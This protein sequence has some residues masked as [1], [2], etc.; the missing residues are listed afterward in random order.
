MVILSI[1]PSSTRVGVAMLRPDE[2]LAKGMLISPPTQSG[3]VKLTAVERIEGIIARL[4]CSINLGSL[5]LDAVLVETPSQ[6]THRYAKGSG[7]AGLAL[8]GMAVGAV[9][10]WCRGRFGPEI[11]HAVP[12]DEW[13]SGSSAKR[14]TTHIRAQYPSVDWS[15]DSGADLSDAIAMGLWWMNRQRIKA[16]TQDTGRNPAEV[17]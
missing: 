9:W 16:Q 17:K 5:L 6:H 13:A 2:T 4:H 11:V 12:V 8:Y 15:K 1:D 7:G 14:R 10:Q 3:G